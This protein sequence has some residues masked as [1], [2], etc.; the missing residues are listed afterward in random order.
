MRT[1]VMIT[2]QYAWPMQQSI[3]HVAIKRLL[4]IL[5]YRVWEGIQQS[6]DEGMILDGS[7]HLDRWKSCQSIEMTSVV[8][9]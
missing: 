1:D 7:L 8:E 2:H 5:P 3:Y 9:S 4:R 6:A